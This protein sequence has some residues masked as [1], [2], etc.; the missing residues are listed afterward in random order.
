MERG[1][2]P[3]QLPPADPAFILPDKEAA[4]YARIK[5]SAECRCSGCRLARRVG[6]HECITYDFLVVRCG[7]SGQPPVVFVNQSSLVHLC[8]ASDSAN[9][10]QNIVKLSPLQRVCRPT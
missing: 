9:D 4:T 6:S 10:L 3:I 8:G 1:W 2:Q 5:R 7:S